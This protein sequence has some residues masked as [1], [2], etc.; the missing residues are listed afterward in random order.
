MPEFFLADDL[1]G[2][3]D[4]AGAFF[5]A[6]RRVQVVVAD[7]DAAAGARTEGTAAE[8]V[9]LTTESRNDGAAMAAEKVRRVVGR[10]RAGGGRVVFKKIDSTMRGPVAAELAALV[11]ALP[12]TRILFTPANPAA[13]RTVRDGVLYVQGVPVAETEFARD[14]AKP[15]L[16]SS[17]RESLGPELA[18]RVALAD[19]ASQD[20]LVAAVARMNAAGD[21]WI[22]VGSAA[23][24]RAMMSGCGGGE[25]AAV[26]EGPA[27]ASRSVLLVCCSAHPLNRTQADRLGRERGVRVHELLVAGPQIAVAAATADLHGERSAALLVQVARVDRAEALQASVAAA[28]QLCTTAGV[29]RVFVTGGETAFGLCQALGIGRLDFLGEIEPGVSVSAGESRLGPMLL[30]VKPGGF[31]DAETWVRV[32]DRLHCDG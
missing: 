30:A 9:A 27:I 18:G 14:P 1:S 13:G 15:V 12:G 21:D 5:R 24:A 23:L 20:D 2:A 19:A 28:V 31:G 11:E 6:G 8:V 25:P 32:F 4:A 3:L 7:G 29:R 26:T 17:L 10:V 16:R 22:G